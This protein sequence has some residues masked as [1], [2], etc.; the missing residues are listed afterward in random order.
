[1]LFFST[2]H[3]LPPCVLATTGRHT[4]KELGELSDGGVH[5]K[6][7]IPHT[8]L[9]IH[10]VSRTTTLSLVDRHRHY[11]HHLLTME[12]HACLGASLHQ[13]QLATRHEKKGW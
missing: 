6:R 8:T 10:Q 2:P 12:L 5:Q 3:S 7:S 11:C 13:T 4:A 1:M 9:H